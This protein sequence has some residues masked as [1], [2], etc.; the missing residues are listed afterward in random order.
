MKIELIEKWALHAYA[1]GQLGPE[2]SRE[3]EEFLKSNEEARKLVADIRQQQAALQKVYHPVLDEVVPPEL[4][5]MARGSAPTALRWPKW[6]AAAGLAALL[7]GGASGWFA[8]NLAGSQAMAETLPDRAL[9]AFDVFASDADHAVEFSGSD[10]DKLGRWLVE[11]IGAKFSIPDL[12]GKGFSFV[13]GRMLAEQDRPAG[14][15]IYEDANKARLVMY[16]AANPA[17]NELPMTVTSRGKLVT[18]YWVESD[19]V[20]ALA[21]EQAAN[22][23]LPLAKEAHED[24]DKDG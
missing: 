19:L 4:L 14:L 9:N 13:G 17:K 5:R 6:A 22:I 11:R 7:V 12:S 18:C 15:L 10:K 16:V 3:V 20:Y 24:F 1:D 8:H 2:E 21:G 23:M